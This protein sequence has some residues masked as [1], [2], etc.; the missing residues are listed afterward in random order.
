MTITAGTTFGLRATALLEVL[1]Q[2]R[3]HAGGVRRASGAPSATSAAPRTC[4]P[5]S[6]S[7]LVS[8][9]ATL[10]IVPALTGFSPRSPGPTPTVPDR[11][12]E[13]PDI[14]AEDRFEFEFVGADGRESRGANR[15][16]AARTSCPPHTASRTTAQLRRR[17][18]SRCRSPPT[19]SA[20]SSA[21]RAWWRRRTPSARRPSRRSGTLR[22]RGGVAH[23]QV[24]PE[25]RVA[26][27]FVGQ[28]L[29]GV[30]AVEFG[31][32]AQERHPHLDEV[33]RRIGVRI[34]E[35]IRSGGW[36]VRG[37]GA[38]AIAIASARRAAGTAAAA[39]ATRRASRSRP[40]RGWSATRSRSA[41][42]RRG[43]VSCAA[44]RASDQR[45]LRGR[46]P[47]AFD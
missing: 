42:E 16:R 43:R 29:P 21:G 23:E 20:S 5:P 19:R 9:A 3:R 34:C 8:V 32:R 33:E 15:T 45:V 10:S 11:P 2:F 28:F 40:G 41:T 7:A 37:C 13:Q 14:G 24:E 17:S 36:T 26:G 22:P 30:V 1:L 39:R 44:G 12:L 46:A 35:P 6:G 38:I 47:S 31:D 27:E 4:P 18:G 25:R